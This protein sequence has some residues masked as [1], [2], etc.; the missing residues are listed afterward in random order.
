MAGRVW[1]LACLAAASSPAALAQIPGVPPP[2]DPN[3]FRRQSFQPQ[4]QQIELP[5]P[6]M[7][8]G[9][10]IGNAPAR[11]VGDALQGV[12]PLR[13]A[14]LLKSAMKEEPVA[15]LRSLGS[16]YVSPETIASSG[17]RIAYDPNSLS[18][19][20]TVDPSLLR[21]VDLFLHQSEDYGNY[22]QIE[23]SRY[24]LG[25]DGGL[26]VAQRLNGGDRNTDVR[27]H[28][29]GFANLGGIDGVYA[30]FA[31]WANFDPRNG[32]R[33][34]NRERLTLFKD[35]RERAIRYSAVDVRPEALPL[36]GASSFL[37][38]GIERR[39]GDIRPNEI[40]RPLGQSSILLER[41]ATVEI[42]VNGALLRRFEA[43]AGRINLNDIPFVNLG[44]DV[45]IYVEDEFGRREVDAFSFS[46]RENL[47]APGVS[48][49]GL[50]GGALQR[51]SIGGSE[52]ATDDYGAMAYYRQGVTPG[53]TLGAGATASDHG[54]VGVA[55]NVVAA[56]PYGGGQLD[57]AWSRADDPRGGAA[58]GFS[59]AAS[60]DA[61]FDGLGYDK[62]QLTLR[63][64]YRSKDF[65]L[66]GEGGGRDER[67]SA[68]AAYR[69]RFQEGPSVNLGAGYDR[70]GDLQ[71]VSLRA[72][73]SHSFGA[74][75]ASAAVEH[76]FRDE[77]RSDDTR[78]LLSASMPLGDDARLRA[79]Y[80]SARDRAALEYDKRHYDRVGD[81][82]YN[83]RVERDEDSVGFYG[84]ADY[85]GNRFSVGAALNQTAESVDAVFDR[86]SP[87]VGA[88]RLNSGVGIA[89]GRV[90]VGRRVGRGFLLI[91]PHPTLRDS[92]VSIGDRA[93]GRAPLVRTDGLGPIVAPISGDY[94]F[95]QVSL[96]VDEAPIGYDVGSGVYALQSG[97]RVGAVATV[98]GDAFYSARGVLQD[99]AGQPVALQYGRLVPQD[100]RAAQDLFTNA[101]GVFFASGLAPGVYDLEIAGLRSRIEIAVP[102]EGAL[103]ELGAVSLGEGG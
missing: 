71:N 72:G 44:N 90:G 87:L 86:D 96:N 70:F 39:Y 55:G 95:S 49:F 94:R 23:P 37:G 85:I 21:D 73:A 26:T 65:S 4:A 82:G 58:S 18:L 97:A 52:W 83:L 42:E 53:L 10:S 51:D 20:L 6:T 91:D 45:R 50:A 19:E 56:L 34:I 33:A 79:S 3:G 62:D 17:V 92:V 68:S 16:G 5:I 80:A 102:A 47:L 41:P 15:R 30:D 66:L 14:D 40:V 60:Y 74:L 32:E 89:D 31:G 22:A 81:Y 11:L 100:G 9:R 69:M 57:A 84:R 25:V 78:I 28:L 98:G 7:L 35:D 27:L 67:L 24:A 64:E 46:A 88:L 59:L 63:A 75:T 8:W 99:A 2:P 43:P 93:D 54:Y 13:L 48:E 1:L 61:E 101:A 76:V 77:G 103:I 36:M 38:V 12:D 29:D